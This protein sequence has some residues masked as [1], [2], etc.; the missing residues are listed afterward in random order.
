V[1][2]VALLKE[3][4]DFN[5]VDIR[6]GRFGRMF[7]PSILYAFYVL[8]TCWLHVHQFS[9]P[10]CDFTVLTPVDDLTEVPIMKY[11]KL[12]SYLIVFHRIT[13]GQP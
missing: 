6:S 8:S 7:S 3:I 10:L 5:V 1:D 4:N 13:E 12:L 11:S 9:V 2:W